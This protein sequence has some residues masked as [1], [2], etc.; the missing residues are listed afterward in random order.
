ML[1]GKGCLMNAKKRAVLAGWLVKNTEG[2]RA[3][4]RK[5]KMKETKAGGWTDREDPEVNC[6]S[7]GQALTYLV[8]TYPLGELR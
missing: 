7:I 5:N 8:Q 4:L 3:V 2:R 1:P 6:T